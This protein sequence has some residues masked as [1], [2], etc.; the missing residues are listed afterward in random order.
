MNIVVHHTNDG[1]TCEKCELIFNAF[2]DFDF[3]IKTWFLRFR[4]DHPEFHISCAGR[5]RAEQ[6]NLFARKAS[7]AHYGQSA[8]NWNCAIDTFIDLPGLDLY[9]VNHYATVLA[10]AV[11]DWLNWYGTP[12]HPFHELPHLEKLNWLDLKEQGLLSLV[13]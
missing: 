10:P 12:K 2:P 1:I 6:E 7:L 5:G 11:P 13:E 9:D 8:H 4:I 3:D